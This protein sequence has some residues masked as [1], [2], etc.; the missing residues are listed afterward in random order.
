[1]DAARQTGVAVLFAELLKLGFCLVVLLFM[2]RG[3][4]GLI[5]KVCALTTV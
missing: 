4:V 3:P 2:Q 1:M 5:S